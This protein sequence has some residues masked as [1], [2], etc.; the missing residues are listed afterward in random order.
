MEN[1]FWLILIGN[2]TAC[3]SLISDENGKFD[4]VSIGPKMKWSLEDDT[5]II[6]AVDQSLSIA[7]QSINLPEDSEPGNVSFIIPSDW[8]GPDDKIFPDYKKLLSDL[9]KNLK[10]KPMG[11]IAHS[12]AIIEYPTYKDNSFILLHLYEGG[13]YCSLVYFGK[14]KNRIEKTYSEDFRPEFLEAVLTEAKIDST[15]PPQI[16]VFGEVNDLIEEALKNYPWLGKKNIETF[17]HSPSIQVL[18]ENETINI[19]ARFIVSQLHSKLPD[20]ENEISEQ[21]IT[22]T[23]EVPPKETEEVGPE[24]LGFSGSSKIISTPV[25][26]K[27]LSQIEETIPSPSFPVIRPKPKLKISFP[28]IHFKFNRLLYILALSPLLILI[29]VIFSRTDVD[30]FVT[31]YVFSLKTDAVLDSSVDQVNPQKHIIPVTK[32]TIPVTTS[33][34][35][36]T[37]GQKTIGE[38]AKG[39]ITV[40]NKSDKIQNIPKGTVLIDKS[41]LKFDITNA[42]SISPG[43]SDLEKGVIN[44]GKTNII[45]TAQDIGPEYN[46]SKGATLSFKDTPE[47]ILVSKV[48]ESF[49]GGSKRTINAVSSEDKK[50]IEKKVQEKIALSVEEKINTDLS[51]NNNIIK[52]SIQSKTSRIEYNREVGEEAE[53]LKADISATVSFFV[54]SETVKNETTSS[55]LSSDENFSKAVFD[56]KLFKLNFKVA[57]NETDRSTGVAEIDGK[58]LPIIDQA[59]LRN[60]IRGK[61]KAEAEKIIIEKI[62]RAYKIHINH[63]PPYITFFNLLP[64]R[65]ENINVKV[66]TESL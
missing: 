16:V 6:P 64:F 54:L 46:I 39:E 23:I 42:V 45:A 27:L 41:G 63:R 51:G 57:K 32:K 43:V 55:F 62:P 58:A 61:S 48:N 13:F 52:D 60:S 9:I 7:S 29:P 35:T 28:Q 65:Q 10:L 4:V 49:A 31:P 37:T 15:L 33:L 8:V 56:P 40:Y 19:F 17:L 30:L 1:R 24:D 50:T 20:T 14:I 12:E 22:E 2:S 21:N 34:S 66:N 25:V 18:K 38:K 5:S 3:A 11:Y 26:E 36:K 44:L 53:E 47:S 59:D